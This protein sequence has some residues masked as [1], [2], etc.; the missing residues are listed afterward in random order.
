MLVLTRR[1]GEGI[2]I[3]EG[4]RVVLLEAKGSHIKIGIEAPLETQIYRDEVY[5]RIMEEN[6]KAAAIGEVS[7]SVLTQAASLLTKTQ[8]GHRHE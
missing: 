1:L 3:G 2:R 6:K 7:E 4:V 5:L 8:G